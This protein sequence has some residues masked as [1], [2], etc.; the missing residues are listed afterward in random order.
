MTPISVSPV[1][2]EHLEESYDVRTLYT[3]SLTPSLTHSF[4]HSL[5]P[6]LLPPLSFSR[7]SLKLPLRL[8]TW[9]SKSE[10]KGFKITRCFGNTSIKYPTL[11]CT[12]PYQIY[13]VVQ[14][15]AKEIPHCASTKD[16]PASING[17]PTGSREMVITNC[18]QPSISML[19]LWRWL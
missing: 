2:S 4:T 8:K 9:Y 17:F 10:N 11:N 1:N 19:R 12:L 15:V 14:A 16:L 13:E 7:S 6:S 5:P 3:Y 18:T